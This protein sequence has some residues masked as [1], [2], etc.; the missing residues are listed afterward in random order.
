MQHRHYLLLALVLIFFSCQKF[1]DQKSDQ[2]LVTASTLADLQAIVDNNGAVNQQDPLSG[3]RASDNYYITDQQWQQ[4]T[5]SAAADSRAYIWGSDIYSRGFTDD[6]GYLYNNVQRANTVLSLVDVVSRSAQEEADYRQLKGSAFFIR[7][8][9]FLLGTILWAKTWDASTATA[10]LGIPLRLDPDFNI[11]TI[12]SSVQATYEQIIR[13]FKEAA[14]LLPVYP[15]HPSRASQPA[16]Y[17]FLA[18]TYLAMRLY[19][20]AGHYADL[21]LQ[22]KKDLLNLNP[23]INPADIFPIVRFN[24]EVI[25]DASSNVPS[26]M[27]QSIARIDSVLFSSFE[28]NDLRRDVYFRTNNNGTYAFKGNYSGSNTGFTGIAVD[29]VYLM[30]AEASA[31][32][33]K[34]TEALHDLNQLLEKKWRAGYYVPYT[35]SDPQQALAFILTERRKQ[36]IYRGLRWMDVKRLNKEGYNIVLRRVLAGQVYELPPNDNRYALPLPEDVVAISGIEQN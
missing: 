14:A 26:A 3:E 15:A 19:D 30:R 18:R 5:S 16:A 32:K 2:R 28:I 31:R 6:W 24:P 27:S 9:S 10:D 22:L 1:L 34:V 11:P 36:L 7:A 8:R 23:P 33:G 29:E 25:Y 13:D 21:C 17:G 20:S 12:R 35:T 4:L